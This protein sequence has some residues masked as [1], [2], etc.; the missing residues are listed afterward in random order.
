MLE[1]R[2]HQ[3]S[4]HQQAQPKFNKRVH[5]KRRKGSTR[6]CRQAD[7][8]D[9]TIESHRT[10]ATESQPTKITGKAEHWESHNQRKRAT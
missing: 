10:P 9:L 5:T 7:Q 4:S 8:R 6:A 3:Q 1:R 2:T